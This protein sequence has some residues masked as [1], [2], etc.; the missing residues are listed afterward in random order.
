MKISVILIVSMVFTHLIYAQDDQY[1]LMK[2]V[3]MSIPSSPAFALLGVNPEIVLRPGDLRS[4]K[5]DW[6]IK[7]YNLAPDLAI[8]GQP[9][10]HFYFK[11]KSWLEYMALSKMARKLS[12][13]SVSGAT[14][15][16]DGINHASYAIK[17]NL[18]KKNDPLT[19][20]ILSRKIDSEV[21]I[22][23][24]ILSRKVDSLIS[25]R[26]NTTDPKVKEDIEVQLE[27]IHLQ[28]VGISQEAIMIYQNMVEQ[29]MAEN[30]NQTM[31]DFAFGSVYTYDNASLDSLKIQKAG[32]GL[33]ING[34]L[35]S[36]KHGLMTGM[37]RYS[38]I[39]N[40]SNMLYGLGYRY[41]N[42]K[43]NFF[44]EVAFEKLNN[45]FDA[46]GDQPFNDDEIFAA[47]Y[48]EDVGNGWLDF[49]PNE[50]LN[51]WTIAY[52]GDFKL[53]RN[54]LLNF[55][56]RTQFKKDFSLTRLLP[57]ANIICLMK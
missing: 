24:K 8:E 42:V 18:Y 26:Y 56:L 47:K 50:A 35:K 40:K 10:W 25:L 43:Y 46:Q 22:Q 34:C 20:K 7:N 29:F 3:E 27:A 32:F 53:S 16:I 48:I 41:G 11:K 21:E 17:V 45:Y 4:F 6:R 49:K 9:I 36:G 51:Q 54:I 5:V 38:N 37:V 57:V 23:E 12:T 2:N 33:W 28:K 13:L 44:I 19:N 31:L 15:K 55:S 14:A 52:G 30:W 39:Q 1:G